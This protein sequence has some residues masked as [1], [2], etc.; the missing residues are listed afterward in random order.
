MPQ[1]L[2]IVLFCDDFRLE[3][4][5][6]FASA[7]EQNYHII[8]LFIYNKD[9]QGR[10][11]GGASK[12]FLH[13]IL[14][15][16]SKYL[17]QT[18]NSHL[19][20][21]E[22]ETIDILTK[23]QAELKFEKIFFNRS[24]TKKQIEVENEIAKH[25]NSESFKAKLIFEPTEIREIKVFTPFWK[26]CL[27]KMHLLKPA[28]KKPSKANLV[29]IDSL[30]VSELNLLPPQNWW[31]NAISFWEFNYDKIYQNR[32]NFF[33]DKILNYKEDRN[34]LWKE[35]I[36]KFSPYIRFGIL[37]PL[38]L[39]EQSIQK[40]AS[41][42]NEIGWREFSFH[43][44]Y[45][46][47]DLHLV[48]LKKEFSHFGWDKNPDFLKKWQQGKTGEPIIDAG[49][50]ELW[51]TGFMHNRARMI[52]A[53]YLI[54][55]L[56]QNWRDGEEWFWDCL[57][58]A[59][60][61]VNPFAWQ[62]VFGSGYDASPYFRV[63]NPTLQQEKFDPENVYINKWKANKGL[64]QI[65]QHDIQRKKVLLKYDEIM[66]NSTKHPFLI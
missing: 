33:D 45:R 17:E 3:D 2:A 1:K 64:K 54:K 8:P 29:K 61:A 9:Y 4:N 23:L 26:E 31:Q 50:T 13:F 12:V 32:D 62:W 14:Q 47:Q 58:D 38:V 63:F 6:A 66:K 35:G 56:L 46:N 44:L 55:D 48:E 57:F 34:L 51:Q 27:S 10:E 49:M 65:V 40:S 22:G 53:S 39:F 52:T 7:V 19:I 30:D 41:F 16:F 21:R 25:F 15:S 24:Y 5:P 20:I 42:N 11:L 59:C 43:T 18:Y 37:S 36:S 60:P 28:L